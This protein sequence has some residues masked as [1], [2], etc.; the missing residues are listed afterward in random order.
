[1][2]QI[3]FTHFSPSGN[4]RFSAQA[5]KAEKKK[6][7]SSYLRASLQSCDQEKNNWSVGLTKTDNIE[8]S[9]IPEK[10]K[11]SKI[12][13]S[14]FLSHLRHLLNF[15]FKSLSDLHLSYNLSSFQITLSLCSCHSNHPFF[16]PWFL[17]GAVLCLSQSRRYS[18]C[19]SYSG[20]VSSFSHKA[21]P[22]GIQDL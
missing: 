17:E 10:D 22:R 8:W 13:H 7:I 11:C 18:F 3:Y 5:I 19:S 4:Y 1:M 14:L 21:I 9:K 12:Q 20:I 15:E 2:I 16:P 6:V